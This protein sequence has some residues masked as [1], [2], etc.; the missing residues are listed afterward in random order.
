VQIEA[1]AKAEGL[2]TKVEAVAF[3]SSKP[4]TLGAVFD[5]SLLATK[6]VAFDSKPTTATLGAVFD[7]NNS[8]SATKV[9]YHLTWLSAAMATLAN[10]SATTPEV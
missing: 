2:L 1:V 9:A 8:L 10:Q 5:N 3:D 7:S 6:A 4:T